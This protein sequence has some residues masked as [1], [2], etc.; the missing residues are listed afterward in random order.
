MPQ[1]H[2][3]K[4][5][6]K[7]TIVRMG[8]DKPIEVTITRDIIRVKSV[9][10]HPEGTDVG[11][12]DAAPKAMQTP[13]AQEAFRNATLQCWARSHDQGQAADRPD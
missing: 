1:H 13:Q 3:D 11:L 12:A 9:R 2:S 8:S 5:Y 4:E 6:R 10:S 7:L